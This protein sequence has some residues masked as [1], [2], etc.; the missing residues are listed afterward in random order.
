[1]QQ[2]HFGGQM[3]CYCINALKH[4]CIS[5]VVISQLFKPSAVVVFLLCYSRACEANPL[6]TGSWNS[7]HHTALHQVPGMRLQK[8]E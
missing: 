4:F 1:M 6:S 3:L 8:N 5:L 2:K 7:I